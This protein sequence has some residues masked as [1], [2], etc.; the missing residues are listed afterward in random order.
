MTRDADGRVTV[1]VRRW[2]VVFKAGATVDAA[3]SAPVLLA[4]GARR[5]CRLSAA[6]PVSADVP[7][8]G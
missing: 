8:D 7:D 5:R 2:R 4:R 6:G 3:A 1:T